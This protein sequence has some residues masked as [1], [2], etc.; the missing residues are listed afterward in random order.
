MEQIAKGDRGR[1][2]WRGIVSS[3]DHEEASRSQFCWMSKR[4]RCL[5]RNLK[6]PGAELHLMDPW[7]DCQEVFGSWLD[8]R[9]NEPRLRQ[10]N[11]ADLV[12]SA[13]GLLRP[14]SVPQKKR[15]C[16]NCAGRQN[17]GGVDWTGAGHNDVD[18]RM[19]S[20]TRWV[21]VLMKGINIRLVWTKAHATLEE[22]TKGSQTIAR[23]MGQRRFE[24]GKTGAIQDGAEVAERVAKKRWINEKRCTR[25][26]WYAEWGR[27]KCPSGSS[28]LRKLMETSI[29]WSEQSKVK[30][31]SS[32]TGA[33]WGACTTEC[34][35]C[36]SRVKLGEGDQE[37][38]ENTR[39][40]WKDKVM[41]VH[42]L[43]PC[44][45]C[46]VRTLPWCRKCS[47]WAYENRLGDSV[48]GM[49]ANLE[50]LS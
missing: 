49:S 38:G 22:K 10:S 21:S 8:G 47:S 46:G 20:G 41:G 11:Y 19:L 29:E 33:V 15:H 45:R 14:K 3:V 44:G 48:W 31:G 7:E 25:L 2:L 13:K 4:P 24:V 28:A 39:H 9:A 35:V 18:L 12:G 17:D 1:W 26:I 42:H 5:N 32:A 23:C 36:V 30:I 43:H 27:R 34:W 16:V 40:S 6:V 37:R 50:S